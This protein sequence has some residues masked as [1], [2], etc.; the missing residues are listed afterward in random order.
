MSTQLKVVII[1]QYIHVSNRYI[2]CL[3]LTPCYTSIISQFKG[4]Y[5][6]NW[7][8]NMLKQKLGSNFEPVTNFFLSPL[9]TED[10]DSL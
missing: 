3:K 6:T 5:I 2:V 7:K 10:M 1:L 8:N 9:L 4:K